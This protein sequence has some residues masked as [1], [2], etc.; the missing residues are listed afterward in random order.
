VGNV[1][2]E[3]KAGT[4][5]SIL[6]EHS[7]ANISRIKIKFSEGKFWVRW[8]NNCDL[9]ILERKEKIE[10]SI[11]RCYATPSTPNLFNVNSICASNIQVAR[12]DKFED[13]DL[14]WIIS[15]S[16]DVDRNIEPMTD[17]QIE[18]WENN[19]DLLAEI[20]DGVNKLQEAR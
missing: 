16:P 7:K 15:Y 8:P 12:L 3:A 14:Y 2:L 6:I 17:S 20:N 5:M 13:V 19:R 10:C 9:N 4:K 11:K 18:K 1:P